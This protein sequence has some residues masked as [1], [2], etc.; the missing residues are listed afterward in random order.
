MQYEI[1]DLVR[2]L[3]PFNEAYPGVYEITGV[4][5]PS[6]VYQILDE[7]DFDVRYLESAE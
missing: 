4:R 5:V 2:V 6:Q 7:R 3:A 1:G